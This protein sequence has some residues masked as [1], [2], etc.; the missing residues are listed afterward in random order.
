MERAHSEDDRHRCQATNVQGQCRLRAVQLPTGDFASYCAVHGGTS[1]QKAAERESL[2]NYQLDRW[3][4][5]LLSKTNSP[6]IKSLRDEI[7]ILRVILE[8]RLNKCEDAHDLILQSGPISDMVMKIDRVVNS[9]HKLEG[10]MG[11]LL[12]KS[13]ILQFA[14][15]V[16]QILS[17][18]VD[19]DLLAVIAS[20]INES[21]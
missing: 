7:G 19:E 20:E 8:E 4:A 5:K 9:C 10:A 15:Q 1:Q 2:R 17:N 12:D 16:I 14:Q 18:H 3:K 11:L 21:I 6:D 13:A